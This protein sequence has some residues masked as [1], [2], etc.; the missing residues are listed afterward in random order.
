[1]VE[2][3]G[4][5]G[6][7]WIDKVIKRSKEFLLGEQK[8]LVN[9]SVIKFVH[10]KYLSLLSNGYKRLN[11]VDNL[12]NIS[13][14]KWD[15]NSYEILS[16]IKN[17]SNMNLIVIDSILRSIYDLATGGKI[18]FSKLDPVGVSQDN[19]NATPLQDKN[20]LVESLKSGLNF[21][22]YALIGGVII[23]GLILFSKV[24]K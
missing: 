12:T 23:G 4:F 9:E 22:K 24:K 5:L 10:N 21:S 19:T 17:E 8:N 18:S 1:M 16:K 7:S 3:M 20:I 2:E 13:L 11:F 6:L 15:K 14:R